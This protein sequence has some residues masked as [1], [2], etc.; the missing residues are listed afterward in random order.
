MG[1]ARR[2]IAVRNVDHPAGGPTGDA[3]TDPVSRTDAAISTFVGQSVLA[4]RY[5]VLAVGLA[6][7]WWQTIGAFSA[8]AAGLG[9]VMFAPGIQHG[10]EAVRSRRWPTTEAIVTESRVLTP[11]EA[12]QFLGDDETGADDAHGGQGPSGYVPLVRYEFTVDSSRYE[13]ARLSP[14]DGPISRRTWADAIVNDYPRGTLVS[15]RY[16]PDDPTRSYLRPAVRSSSFV[17]ASIGVVF[18]A[19]A[20]WIA[21]GFPGGAPAAAMGVGIPLTAFGIHRLRIGRRS[22]DWPTA[23]GEVT[24]TGIAAEGGGDDTEVTYVPELRYE[25]EAAGE[26]YVSS[27][28]GFGTMPTFSER[29]AARAWIDERYPDGGA[30]TVH[31]DPDRPDRSVLEPGAGRSLLAV[32]AGLAVTG[33]G[34]LMLLTPWGVL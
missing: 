11:L 12:R 14:F 22:R 29:S 26:R 21:A 31:Y 20:V 30:V 24:S 15:V 10:V 4:F 33:A 6:V 5:L 17:F 16:D 19:I 25:Y 3:S 7:V 9:F 2:A 32:A 13:N 28:H 18:L 34:L 23:P 27:R 1:A 8:F